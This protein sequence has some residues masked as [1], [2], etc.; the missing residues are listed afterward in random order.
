MTVAQPIPSRIKAVVRRESAAPVAPSAQDVGTW[1]ET[2]EQLD[3]RVLPGVRMTEKEFEAWSDED[4]RAEWIDGEVLLVAPDNIEH[5]DSNG[6]LFS[7]I[8]FF[9]EE[10]GAGRVFIPNVQV[11][12]PSQNRRRIPDLLFVSKSRLKIVKKT[13]VD[14]APDLV[15]EIV[16]P[17]SEARDWRE[18]Y[19][20]YQAAGV[21]EYWII[22][23]LSRRIEAYALARSKKY[24]LIP[25]DAD[26]CIHSKVLKGLYLRPAWLWQSPRPKLAA[27]TKELGLRG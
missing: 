23:P 15:M 4:V 19:L 3:G 21:R 1:V 16:S 10:H 22:D 17:D 13:Y 20:E 2:A 7:L 27:V 6:W 24:T 18:K 26:G 8:R 14:G 5:A 11:R 9:V 12:L 25:P